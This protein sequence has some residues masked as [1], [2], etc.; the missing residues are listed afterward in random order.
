MEAKRSGVQPSSSSIME[1][2]VGS[3]KL[4][5]VSTSKSLSRR[6]VDVGSDKL[7]IRLGEIDD[8]TVGHYLRLNHCWGGKG[9]TQG[10]NAA[11]KQFSEDPIKSLL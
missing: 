3:H 4:D 2:N 10:N 1:D 5:N 8:S 11:S 7:S 6:Q 9:L